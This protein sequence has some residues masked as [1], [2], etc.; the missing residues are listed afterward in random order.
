MSIKHLNLWGTL[1]YG[2]A[3][4]TYF[5]KIAYLEH[6]LAFVRNTHYINANVYFKLQADFIAK[7]RRGFIPWS[8][9]L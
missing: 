5:A 9:H 8:A 4:I 1:R 6:L 2:L 3:T 7:Q